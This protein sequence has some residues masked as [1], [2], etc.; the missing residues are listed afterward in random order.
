LELIVMIEGTWPPTVGGERRRAQRQPCHSECR[1]VVVH[2]K[3]A[4]WARLRDFS[5][6]G[7]GI[8]VSGPLTPGSRVQLRTVG[9]QGRLQLSAEVRYAA[10][11]ADGSWLVGCLLDAA[12]SWNRHHGQVRC[13]D[14]L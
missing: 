12:P 11:Q 6:G 14:R 3:E 5:T 4:R 10:R 7:V 13:Q 8:D 9:V 2:D 1:L